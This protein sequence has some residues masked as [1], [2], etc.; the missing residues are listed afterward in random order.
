MSHLYS[1]THSQGAVG[2]TTPDN[3]KYLLVALVRRCME[4]QKENS[5][6][7]DDLI[8]IQSRISRLEERYQPEVD[9][10]NP[11]DTYISLIQER[12]RALLAKEKEL[13]NLQNQLNILQQAATSR[14]TRSVPPTPLNS[15]IK[16]TT[17]STRISSSNENVSRR[18]APTL[19]SSSDS[20]RRS[21]SRKESPKP[22]M[23]NAPSL[24]K[25]WIKPPVLSPKNGT[26]PRYR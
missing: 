22:S 10:K 11:S 13:M 12:D 23:R 9:S 2:H 18:R 19:L 15:S 6:L 5:K 21:M 16:P 24:R 7:S 1:E 25:S 14:S 8:S 17:S 4:L 3:R 26:I 20:R